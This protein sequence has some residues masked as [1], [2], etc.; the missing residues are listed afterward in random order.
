MPGAPNPEAIAWYLERSEALLGQLRG[1]V[2]SLSGRAAQLAGFSGA[3]LAIAG[4]NAESMLDALHGAARIWTGSLLLVGAVLLVS[5]FAT[6]LRVALL[7]QLVSD[8]SAD[9]VANYTSSRFIE[10]AELWRV[11]LR[12]IRALLASIEST[13][14]QGDAAAKRLRTAE[15]L[16]SIG[17]STVG[18]SLAT[19]VVV[20]TF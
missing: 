4:A 19:L 7:P 1:R 14:R 17:L 8:L 12:T 6:A 2:Q 13:T 15:R 16:F 20:V 18:V 5:S 11:H 9:E 10:E 3:V